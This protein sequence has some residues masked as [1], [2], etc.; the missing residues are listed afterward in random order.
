MHKSRQIQSRA[1]VEVDT[2]ALTHNYQTFRKLLRPETKLLAV[3]KSNAYGHDFRQYSLLMQKLGVDWLGADSITEAVPLRESGI[4]IPILVL[5]YT[6]PENFALAARHNVSIT[7]SNIEHPKFLQTK[8]YP[9]TGSGSQAKSRDRLKI[10]LKFDT[11]MC[12][13]GFSPKDTEKVLKY[14]KKELPHVT[15]EGIYTHFAEAKNPSLMVKTLSQWTEFK[16]VLSVLE[17]RN[18][19]KMA[20]IRHAAATGATLTFLESHLDMV[21]IGI[22]MMGYWPEPAMQAR[23]G[24]EITLKP[25]L[26]WKTIISEIK[27]LPQGGTVGYDST[28]RVAPGSRIAILPVGYWHGY[29]RALSGVGNVLIR[30]SRAKVVGRVSMDMIAVDVTH[31]QTVRQGDMVTLVGGEI[32]AEEVASL[33]GTSTYELLTRIN[34]LTLRKY[35]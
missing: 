16:K 9:S 33:A 3:V 27:T 2:K 34:P 4:T 19:S 17:G 25:A 11:G 6:L 14:I 20:L 1:W 21:R 15:I 32:S 29:G 18:P 22:G 23:Y 30:G 5:G 35:Q 8:N 24:K 26:S 10:H 12:R 31:I 28:E 7:V 13:Q